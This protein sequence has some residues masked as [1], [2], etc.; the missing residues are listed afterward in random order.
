MRPH[1]QGTL[2]KEKAPDNGRERWALLR[3]FERAVASGAR[4]LVATAP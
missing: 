2:R 1:T 3:A 4:S